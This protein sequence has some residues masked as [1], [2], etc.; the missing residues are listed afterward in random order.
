MSELLKLTQSEQA[1]RKRVPTLG[2]SKAIWDLQ[3]APQKI[4]LEQ[5]ACNSRFYNKKS[6]RKGQEMTKTCQPK[7]KEEKKRK[8]HPQHLQ[9]CLRQ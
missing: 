1:R 2:T 3:Q 7:E 5:S 8:T 4:F 6:K 9:W